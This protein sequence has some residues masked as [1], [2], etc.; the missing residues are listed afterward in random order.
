MTGDTYDYQ[1]L[2]KD[3]QNPTQIMNA[4]C[5]TVRSLMRRVEGIGHKLYTIFFLSRFIW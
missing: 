2:E 1:N 3:R 5:V 4:T